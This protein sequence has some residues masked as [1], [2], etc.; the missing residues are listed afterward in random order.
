MAVLIEGHGG[1]MTLTL[2]R[3]EKRNA[4]SEAMFRAMSEALVRAAADA[5]VRVVLLRGA[6][7]HFTSGLDLDDL[8][9]AGTTDGAA[10]PWSERFLRLAASFPKPLVASVDGI[11]VGFGCTV[12]LLCDLVYAAEDCRFRTPFVPMGFVPE[13]GSTALLPR[14]AGHHAAAEVLLFGEQFGALQAR[15]LGFVN[16]VLPAA[17]VHRRAEARC[18]QLA[19]MRPEAVTAAKALLRAGSGI[20]LERVIDRENAAF[21]SLLES[22]AEPVSVPAALAER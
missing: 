18:R 17:D 13:A 4:V 19:A 15:A 7:G 2:D 21:R 9:A 1:V 16:E 12:L 14:L 10:T 5:S 3:P 8:Q 6:G 20:D 22:P 11:A